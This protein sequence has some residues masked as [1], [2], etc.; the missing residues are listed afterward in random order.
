MLQLPLYNLQLNSKNSSILDIFSSL[1]SYSEELS[2]LVLLV[3]GAMFS[4]ASFIFYYHWKR[5]GLDQNVMRRVIFLYFSVSAVLLSVMV[6][7]LFV[8]QKSL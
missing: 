1:V 3:I 5:F 4:V 8:Y 2:W 7:S 6:I